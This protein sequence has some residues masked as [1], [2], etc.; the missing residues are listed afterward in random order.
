MKT[1]YTVLLMAAFIVCCNACK[2]D[3]AMGGVKPVAILPQLIKSDLTLKSDSVYIFTGSVVVSNNAVLTIEPGTVIKSSGSHSVFFAIS[4]GSKIMAEGTVDKPIV[5]TSADPSGQRIHGSWSGLYIYGNAPVSVYDEFTGGPGTTMTL[6]AGGNDISGG[7]DNPADNSGVLKYVRIEFAGE[8]SETSYGLALVGVGSGTVVENVQVSYTQ[9]CGFGFY[10]GT[11]NARNLVA[12]N[13]RLAGFVYANGYSGKQQFIVS[14]KHPYFAEAGPWIYTC[15]AVLTFNDIVNN[16]LVVN[17]RPVLSNLTVIGPY[18]N[19]GYNIFKPWN[20]AVNINYGSALA[21]RNTVIMGM[22]EGG[23]KFSDDVA[24]QHLADGTTEFS[25]NLVHN[26]IMEKAFT[27]DMNTVYSLDTTTLNEYA[28]SHGNIRYNTPEEIL[29]TD[30]FTFE[31]P[32]LVPKAGSPALSGADF[33]GTD[34]NSFFEKVTY[35]GAFG[36]VNWMEGWT[37]FYPVTTMY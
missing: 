9:T 12:Y 33:S 27:V 17:T 14:Y 1:S 15:D 31:H 13:N 34:Y 32:G 16:P 22:P 26:N 37:N 20:A 18:N 19:P 23:I 5:F 11:V 7:G 6:R 3:A 28:V 36:T 25:N 29:L 4:R 24:A 35:K 2:K 30:P 10:G 21:L 8:G